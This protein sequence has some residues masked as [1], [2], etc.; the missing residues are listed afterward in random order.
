M[1]NNSSYEFF[2]IEYVIPIVKLEYGFEPNVF[3]IK[4]M[5]VYL[6]KAIGNLWS[7]RYLFI[8]KISGNQIE[9]PCN[10][11]LIESV[12][13]ST[14]DYNN[15]A[16]N[17]DYAN[18]QIAGVREGSNYYANGYSRLPDRTTEGLFLDYKFVKENGKNYL[19]FNRTLITE[20]T[21]LQ[22]IYDADSKR[23]DNMFVNVLYNGQ[24]LNSEG[25]PLITG[26]EAYA[27]A[28]KWIT[29]D[30]RKKTIMGLNN[31]AMLQYFEKEYNKYVNRARNPQKFSQNLMDEIMDAKTSINMKTYGNGYKY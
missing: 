11:E 24:K 6:L 5:A 8:G 18:Q 17:A 2:D 23:L 19:K 22:S 3:E 10:V 27:I 9:L 7:D 29:L 30:Y 25:L 4:D 14:E 31:G 15:Y 21:Q 28:F 20:D 1:M 12:T 13:L 26:D 16:K